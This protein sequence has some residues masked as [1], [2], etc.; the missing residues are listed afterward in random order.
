MIPTLNVTNG[1]SAACLM[2]EAGIEGEILPWRDVLHEGPIPASLSLPELSIVRARFITRQGWGAESD[3]QKDF[4]SRDEALI[5][6]RETHRI[7]LW[8]EHDLY[9]QL[10]LLQI[11]DYFSEH[12]AEAGLSIICTDTYLGCC[13]PE[14]L[15]QLRV[16]EVPVSPDMLSLAHTAWSAFRQPSPEDWFALLQQD[17]TAL[18]FLHGAIKRMLEEYPDCQTGLSRT[19]YQALRLT[20]ESK[21]NPRQLFGAY[22]QTEERRFLGDSSFWLILDSLI[23]S[24]NPALVCRADYSIPPNR[25]QSLEL[26]SNGKAILAGERSFLDDNPL[27]RWIGGVHLQHAN[28]WC[29]DKESHSL[30]HRAQL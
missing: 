10:Q 8:F 11:L 29:W 19:A 15:K 22:I 16:H 23:H 27:N 14:E 7:V 25:E 18:P 20:Q 3:I 6:G 4:Q 9:D 30:H 24:D 5:K 26:T 21:Q 13:D 1:D 17:T 2:R 28:H 12:P